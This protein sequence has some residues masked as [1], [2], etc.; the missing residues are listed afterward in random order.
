MSAMAGS[1]CALCR[2]LSLLPT[3]NTDG[4]GC[5]K[6][7]RDQRWCRPARARLLPA[8]QEGHAGPRGKKAASP[9]DPT[10][11]S[12]LPLGSPA[13]NE[14]NMLLVGDRARCQVFQILSW[15]I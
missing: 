4:G 11:Y 1:T 9:G 10:G 12:T 15:E 6:R 8:D 7:L 2:E 3:E 14:P 5:G 13:N